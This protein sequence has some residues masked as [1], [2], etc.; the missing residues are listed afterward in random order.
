MRPPAF[1]QETEGRDAAFVLRGLLTPV[2]WAYAA[3]TARRIATVEPFR[4][5]VPVV[6]IGNLTMGGTGKTPLVRLV[7]RLLIERGLGA[8]GLS[9]GYGGRLKGPVC[10]DA[11]LHTAQDVGDEPMLLAADGAMWVARDRAAGARAAISA[12]AQ[13]LVL[14]DGHQNPSLHKD[15]RIV[16]VD[17]EAGF[18]NGYVF[19]AGPLREPVAAGLKRTNGVILMRSG[20]E[21]VGD[22]VDF[23]P[24][25]G[26]I[27]EAWLAPL[28]DVPSGPLVAFCGIG[29]PKK[30]ADTLRKMGA[31]VTDLIPFPDHH[32]Y[33]ADELKRLAALAKERGARLVTTEKD[34]VR[35]PLDFRADVKTIRVETHLADPTALA[36]L[37]LFGDAA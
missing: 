30:F 37:L 10:V 20:P 34:A 22:P 9:R 1:W 36:A 26:P 11:G 25:D 15:V 24:W 23:L 35:L 33:Q 12:G 32:P 13:A 16:V 2:S 8:A 5:S 4:A 18:G 28:G 3:A 21:R 31:D 29:R 27:M 6:S 19:P 17:A 7:R 14:D